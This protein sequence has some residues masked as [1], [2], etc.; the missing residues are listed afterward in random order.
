MK[1]PHVCIIGLGRFGSALATELARRGCQVTAVDRDSTIVER[2][3]ERVDHAL[4]ADI[5][6][7]GVL[8]ELHLEGFDAVC[9][10]I[11]SELLPFLEVVSALGDEARG[12]IYCRTLNDAH[13]TLIERLGL[14]HAMEVEKIAAS[15]FAD[16]IY[17]PVPC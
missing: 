4:V 15:H 3:A 17:G 9:V 2:I 12:K 14:K 5:D 7:R 11:G 13:R 1:H 10:A 6:N 16:E 8:E